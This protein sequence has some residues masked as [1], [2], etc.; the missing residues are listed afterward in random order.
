MSQFSLKP[1]W[2]SLK[3]LE[4]GIKVANP[5]KLER[6]GI[7]RRFEIVYEQT[8]KAAQRVL[9]EN[10]VHA[11][12]PKDVFRELGRIGWIDNVETWIQFQKSRNETGHEYGEKFAQKSH[13]L[14]KTFLPLGAV[15]LKIL[16]EKTRESI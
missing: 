9:R 5:S 16:T 2:D 4:E 10:E 6:D 15:L 1:A 13:D 7:V 14:A 11:E 8:W 3:N 12:T